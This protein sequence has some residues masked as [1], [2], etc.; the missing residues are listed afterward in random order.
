MSTTAELDAPVVPSDWEDESGEGAAEGAPAV[1]PTTMGVL[2]E[3]LRERQSGRTVL[4]APSRGRRSEDEAVVALLSRLGTAGSAS[5]PP[6]P[7]AAPVAS[8]PSS[9]AVRR[10]EPWIAG[11]IGLIVAAGIAA[12]ATWLR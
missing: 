1:F 12:A 6:T 7:A 10:L 8:E 5:A 11:L 9:A 2:L 3:D 4:R